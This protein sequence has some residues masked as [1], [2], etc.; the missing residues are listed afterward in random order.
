ME[1][2]PAARRL[3]ALMT[4]PAAEYPATWPGRAELGPHDLGA[5]LPFAYRVPAT[6]AGTS[7]RFMVEDEARER[8]PAFTPESCAELFAA[9]VDGLAT[10]RWADLHL[11]AASLV[12]CP[13]GPPLAALAAPARTLVRFLLDAGRTD[14]PYALLAVAGL[15]GC[16]GRGDDGLGAEVAGTIEAGRG[17]IGADEL[18]LLASWDA[19]RRA[20]FLE[21]L[22]NRSFGSPPPLPGVWERLA[23]IPGYTAFA[24]A[25]LETAAARV[26]AI[27]AG[28][29]PYRA[30]RA[31]EASETEAL[32]RAVRLALAR[33]EEWLPGLL[34]PLLTGVAVAPGPAR[35]LPSQAL[36]YEIARAVEDF[37]TPEAV[38]AL[39]A[40]RGATRHAG[41]PRRLD[42]M[43]KRI[44]R[45]LADRVEV[46]F[47]MPDLG[48]GP[49]GVLRVP[50]GEHTGVITIGDGV[51]LT[52]QRGEKRSRSVPAA[53]RRD[54]PG[55]LKHLREQVQQVRRRLTT[56][57]RAL[58][59][60]YPGE[61]V[62][63]YARWRTEIA[64][65]PITGTVAGRLIWEFEHSPGRW[66]SMMGAEPRDAAGE[67][68]TAPPPDTPVRLWH[69]ARAPLAEVTAWRDRVTG[70]RIRQPFKQA[71]REVYLLTP[72]EEATRFHS[73]RFAAHIVAYRTLYALF[74]QR[75]WTSSM[76]GP[77][78]GG[79]E[80]EARR[81]LA[82]GRWRVSLLHSYLYGETEERAV[83][84]RV[85][86]HRKVSGEWCEAPLPEVPPLV[87]S[88]AM[89]DVDL[90]VALTSIAT[91]PAWTGDDDGHRDYRHAASSAPLSPSAEVRRD[92]LARLLP[93]TAIAGRCTLTDR[94]LVVRG[95]LRTYRIHLGSAGVLMEPGDAHLCVVA[96]PAAGKG[97]FLP[98]EDDGRLAL[99]LSK[100]FLLAHDT[101]ITDESILRQIKG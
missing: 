54:H 66:R 75:G 59:G 93:R 19:G 81:V 30:D 94:H 51:E 50:A 46:A 38:T 28:E 91:D 8:Q 92:A 89:R 56:L 31:F 41:V 40:A 3:L 32:G 78:D 61:A 25:A 1:L 37:P 63:P 26:A 55:E 42:R 98:F 82:G 15:A 53:V 65:H 23:D 88:E 95:D 57:V 4:D 87:F 58:E 17:P 35:T 64:G 48:F 34:T 100:A 80:D 7:A 47:R 72:A 27:H 96:A 69:P 85:R 49:G 101:D 45:A 12:R 24:R 9:L 86:F 70:E 84:G 77:W 10:R 73:A 21:T 60:G 97:L 11:G 71:F 5:L 20:L 22:R 2:S 13:D 83:T 52:W 68:V 43:L 62:H 14:Q 18:R 44:D 99:I 90:F 16:D 33:D 67:P 76:L 6:P 39:R 74:R 79:G 29:I 36:L